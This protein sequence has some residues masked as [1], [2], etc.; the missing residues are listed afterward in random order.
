MS[1]FLSR[2]TDLVTNIYL[3]ARNTLSDLRWSSVSS[4]HDKWFWMCKTNNWKW[5]ECITNCSAI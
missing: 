1:L 5:G 4:F 2:K 3:L